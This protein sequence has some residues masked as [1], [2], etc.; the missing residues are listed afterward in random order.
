MTESNGHGVSA[1]EV[2]VPAPNESSPLLISSDQQSVESD[3]TT[4]SEDVRLW[5]ELEKPWPSTYERSISLLASPFVQ[6]A[7]VDLY[8]KSP[9]PGSTPA[10][11]ARRRDL[12]RGFYTPEAAKLYRPLQPAN[13]ADTSSGVGGGMSASVRGGQDFRQAMEKV[14]SLDFSSKKQQLLQ[15]HQQQ[16]K[17]AG[18][19]KKYREKFLNKRDEEDGL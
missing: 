13:L 4:A 12:R 3:T 17:K 2:E 7:Q 9:K 10:A 8:T 1:T 19:A 15:T 5:E 18:E 6:T 16:Q 14:K 11:L